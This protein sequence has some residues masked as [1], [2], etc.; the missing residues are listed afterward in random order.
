MSLWVYSRALGMQT[1]AAAKHAYKDVT[2][3]SP[4]PV[5]KA[6]SDLLCLPGIFVYLICCDEVFQR[7][8]LISQDSLQVESPEFPAC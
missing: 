2:L 4:H 8:R 5:M 7:P 1:Q 3:C 6:Y